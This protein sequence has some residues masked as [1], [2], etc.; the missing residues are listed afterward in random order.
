MFAAVDPTLR[1]AVE[2][3]DAYEE[4][5]IADPAGWVVWEGASGWLGPEPYQWRDDRIQ[6]ARLAFKD[7]DTTK[8]AT[9]V[10]DEY[11]A[12]LPPDYP[13]PIW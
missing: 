5:G 12:S 6:Q 13:F 11:L 2:W 4:D 3:D 10:L 8:P 7:Y 1:V 9:Q